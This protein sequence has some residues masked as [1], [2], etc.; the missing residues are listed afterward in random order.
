[1]AVAHSFLSPSSRVMEMFGIWILEEMWK[2]STHFIKKLPWGQRWNIIL[3]SIQLNAEISITQQQLCFVKSELLEIVFGIEVEMSNTKSILHRHMSCNICNSR[4]E[5]KIKSYTKTR[6]SSM[7]IKLQIVFRSV[8][9]RVKNHRCQVGGGLGFQRR[10]YITI[11]YMLSVPY[12]KSETFWAPTRSGKFYTWPKFM[13]Q[14][15]VKTQEHNRQF[16]FF[17]ASLR[18]EITFRLNV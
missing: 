10:M 18:E 3:T 9:C 2:L 6:L 14:V 5:M 4:T 1:M 8:H 17:S 7:L 16:W 13:G 15:T 11:P 12:P